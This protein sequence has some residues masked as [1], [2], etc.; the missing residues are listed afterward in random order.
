VTLGEYEN[1]RLVVEYKW[2]EKK[3]PPREDRPRQSG[4]VLHATRFPG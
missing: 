3:W 4:I 1:D 2:G